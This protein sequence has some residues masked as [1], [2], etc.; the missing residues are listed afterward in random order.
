MLRV[1]ILTMLT[2]LLAMAQVSSGTLSGNVRDETASV[3]PGVKIVARQSNTGFVRTAETDLSGYYE[4]SDLAPGQYIVTAEKAGFRTTTVTGVS[5]Q[6]NQR[7]R[8]DL[9]LQVGAERDSVTVTASVSTL[10]TEN[11]SQDYYLGAGTITSLPLVGRNVVSLLT[12]GPGA[13]PRQLSGFVHD[14]VNDVQPARGAVELNPP[15]NGARSTMNAHFLDGSY[16]TDR[17]AFAIAVISPLE[18]VQEFRTQ[19]S[20]SSAEFPQAGGGVVDIVTKSGSRQ[21]HGSVFE[22]FRNEATDARSY[23]DDP[24]LP[25]PIFRQNQFGGSLSGPLPLASTFFFATYEGLRGQS[26][27]S[28]IH[29]VPDATLRTGNFSGRPPIFDALTLNALTGTREPFADGVIPANR[30]DPIATNYLSNYEPQPNQ[31]GSGL[32]NYLDAT[33]NENSNDNGSVRVDHQFRSNHSLFGRYTINDSRALLAGNFPERPTIE[34]LRAQQIALGHTLA[35]SWWLNEARASFT[36]L[37]VFD[38]PE[39]A[40]GTDVLREV[41]ISS[42]PNDPSTYGLPYFV[43]TNF[44]TVTDSTRLPQ[45]QRDNTWTLSDGVTFTRGRHTWKTGL[46]WIHF[47]LNYLRSDFIRGRYIFNGSFTSDPLNPAD[48][49]DPFA[50]FLLGFAQSTRRQVGLAQAYLRHDNY[51]AYFQD[52][53][54]VARDLTVNFGVRYEFTS[55][56]SET[57]GNL[58]NLDYSSIPKAPVLV[59]V[60]EANR[61][62]RNNIAPRVGL[63]WKLPRL[64]AVFR[65]GYGVYHNSEIAAE[66]YD[67][68][69]NTVR[70]EINETTGLIPLLTLSNGFPQNSSAGFPSYFGLDAGARTPYL[71]RWNGGFQKELASGIIL[72]LAYVGSKGV[73]LG[74]FRTFNTPLHVETGEDLPP[75]P[76]EL[77]SLRTF[78]ELGPI[79]Q[80]QHIANS[81]YHSLQ[82]KADK[83]LSARLSFLS[84]FVWS[85][86]I[87]D[88]DSVIPG[89]GDSVGAQD[90]RNLR[91]ERGLSVFD[92]GRRLSAGFVCALP[93][94]KFLSR[95][96]A[97]WNMS[98]IVTVQDGSP[99][100]PVY[101]GTDF[102]NS[103]TPNRPDVVPG[104]SITLPKDQRTAESWFN[105]RAFSDPKPFTFGNAGRNTL[106]TPGSAVIDL[107]L[108]RRFPV[109]EH[110]AFQLRIEGF[111]VLNHPNWGIPGQYPDFGPF[112]GKI[113]ATGEPRRFQFAL[114]FDF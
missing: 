57:R 65:G 99:E 37:R 76:G 97:D 15:I 16:N 55:P 51:G 39:S 64:R 45:T 34:D 79:F 91:L 18:S 50:D 114:R 12:L 53:W 107:A 7:A 63:A 62:D 35:G 4:L 56:Y 92:V 27:K 25:Q 111:N 84:S 54:R 89:L 5:L 47:Q 46:Q 70:N 85:K 3:V 14:I 88:A 30:I 32:G 43:V 67:L 44:D 29:T 78:P 82:I 31:P 94:S 11:A 61:P 93:A 98:G 26:A 42:A 1:I 72:D 113:F 86:S 95:V 87:D 68:V 8:V 20:L 75:R 73:K 83:R 71:Q 19:S 2:S 90:E 23:F 28:T 81:S 13:I 52:E 10:Q 6:V 40:F 102:A 109:T 77:Q 17:N 112:F 69:R 58:L 108:Q 66:A 9:A 36:R 33:P 104:Q 105:R 106:P 49:G 41:G 100:N 96:L 59:R 24:T 103:G 22:F 38:L 80:R 101:F 48:T 74:R 110:S 21:F 60:G